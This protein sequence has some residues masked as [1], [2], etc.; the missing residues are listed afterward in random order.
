MRK[1]LSMSDLKESI[2]IVIQPDG[3]HHVKIPEDETLEFSQK[4][5][6]D[7]MNTLTVINEP[8]FVLRA[9]LVLERIMQSI[10]NAVF[11]KG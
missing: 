5:Y 2:V 8:S 9:F 7:M 11:G 1:G 4:A 10:S 3:T 6:S